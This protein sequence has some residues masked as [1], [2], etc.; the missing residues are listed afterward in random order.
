[1]VKCKEFEERMNE[2]ASRLD[3]E[4]ERANIL[5]NEK[6]KL[7]TTIQDLEEQ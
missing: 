2:L 7:G 3:E 6:K 5:V 1:M 4:D